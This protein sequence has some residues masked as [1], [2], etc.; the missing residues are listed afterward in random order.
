MSPEQCLGLPINHRSDIYALT[1]ILYQMLAGKPPFSGSGVGDVLIMQVRAPPPG[2]RL[3]NPAVP[4]SIESAIWRGL[5]KQR[6][7]RFQSMSELVGALVGRGQQTV[8]LP[9]PRP[10]ASLQ[11]TRL[12]AAPATPGSWFTW[13]RRE[14]GHFRG[15]VRAIVIAAAIAVPT[16]LL[17]G[18]DVVR[19]PAAEPT[20][21]APTPAARGGLTPEDRVPALPVA[22]VAVS[23]VNPP[24]GL[25]VTVDGQPAR[26]PLRLPRDGQEHRLELRAPTLTPEMKLVRADRDQ[27]L[28]LKKIPAL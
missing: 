8:A 7:Q 24:V 3:E 19:L 27:S 13:A 1:C 23:I 9:V 15:Q 4:E 16:L 5:A 17:I 25:A 20:T 26:L 11:P 28:T 22:T 2:I 6:E 10:A 18:L 21:F 14:S 12:L